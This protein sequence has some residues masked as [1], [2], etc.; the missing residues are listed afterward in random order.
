ME[1]DSVVGD[2]RELENDSKSLVLVWSFEVWQVL[3]VSVEG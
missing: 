3:D 2:D 1:Y